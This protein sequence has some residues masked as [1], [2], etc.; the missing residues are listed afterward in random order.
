MP[1]I[2]LSPA[3]HGTDN[4]CSFSKSCGENKHCNAYM[5]ELEKYLKACGIEYKRA[6]KANTGDKLKNSIAESN[7]YKPDL[8]YVCHTNASNGKAQ[9]SRPYVWPTGNGKKYAEVIVK[10]RKQIYPYPCA[11]KTN[12][13]WAEINSTKA[14]VVYDEI[15]FHDNA[16]DIKW[17]HENM[18]KMAEY[19]CRA[20]CEIFGVKFVDPYY[21][22]PKPVTPP[23]T[24]SKTIYRV[25]VGAYSDKANADRMAAELKAKGYPAIVIEGGK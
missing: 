3:A 5:D 1:K 8:H 9:G 13:T 6:S 21:V 18:R 7:A 14:V 25:Q 20:F 22:A 10:H 11:V 15:V 24:P 2:Y 16:A 19:T 12:I 4:P 17:F 23:T